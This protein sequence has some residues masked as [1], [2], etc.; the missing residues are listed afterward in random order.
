MATTRVDAPQVSSVLASAVA[1]AQQ[2]RASE[3]DL[4]RAMG[5]VVSFM[6]GPGPIAWEQRVPLPMPAPTPVPRALVRR[7]PAH[8]RVHA[9]VY[10]FGGTNDDAAGYNDDDAQRAFAAL[11]SGFA[12]MR[13]DPQRGAVRAAA[14]QRWVQRQMQRAAEEA[15]PRETITR[16]REAT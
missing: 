11:M 1:L 7:G 4:R 5:R 8:P 14:H 16:K 13:V 12:E 10:V 3:Y 15:Q 2:P 6:F 9:A